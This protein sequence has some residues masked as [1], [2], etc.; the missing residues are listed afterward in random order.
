MEKHRLDRYHKRLVEEKQDLLTLV[1]RV[2]QDGRLADEEGT[3]DLADKAAIAYT[4]EL[5]F[6]QSSSERA[7]LHL[8]EEALDRIQSG[9]YGECLECGEGMD[10]KRLDAVPWARNCIPCQNAQETSTV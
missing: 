5:L 6:H 1:T 4:K 8:I 3:Q 10:D 2:E 9:R 7:V